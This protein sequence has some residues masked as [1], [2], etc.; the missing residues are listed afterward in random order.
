MKKLTFSLLLVTGLISAAIAQPRP[1]TPSP[2]ISLINADGIYVNLSS[3]KGNVVLLDFWA[4]WC[5]P[6]RLAN[7]DMVKLYKKYHHDGFEIFSVSLDNDLQKWTKAIRTDKMTWTNVIDTRAVNGN[8]LSK[9]WNIQ[10]LPYT[11]LIDREGKV[12]AIDPGKQTLEKL[13]KKLL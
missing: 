12:Y 8:A 5:G 3:L 6:C 7:K 9:T 4:S 1:G 11:V 13:V 2:E 10:F